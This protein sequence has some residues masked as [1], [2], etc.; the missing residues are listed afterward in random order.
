MLREL[1]I[2][3]EAS[4]MKELTQKALMLLDL[5]DQSFDLFDLDWKVSSIIVITLMA[6][7]AVTVVVKGNFMRYILFHAPKQR[8]INI[9]IFVDQVS[10]IAC[11]N[12]DQGI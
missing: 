5:T 11:L 6:S 4:A 3:P 2:L 7:L 1:T 12:I 8:P 10:L 9:L